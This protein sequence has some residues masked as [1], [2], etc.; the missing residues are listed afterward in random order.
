MTDN[1]SSEWPRTALMLLFARARMI[2]AVGIVCA[3]GAFVAATVMPAI[4]KGGFSI[5]IKAPEVDLSLVGQNADIVFK[6]GQVAGNLVSDEFQILTSYGLAEAVAQAYL[7]GGKALPGSDGRRSGL[8]ARLLPDDSEAV[9][10]GG[11]GTDEVQ[12][13]AARLNAKLIITPVM[14]SDVIKVEMRDHD[15]RFLERILTLF[16][17]EYLSYRRKIWFNADA[18]EFYVKQADASREEWVRMLDHM[19]ELKSETN[20]IAPAVEKVELEKRMAANVGRLEELSVR[21]AKTAAQ[22]GQLRGLRPGQAL[23]FLSEETGDNRLFWQL[24]TDIAEAVSKREELSKNHLKKSPAMRKM[25]QHLSGLYREY[26]ALT[27]SLLENNIQTLKAERD[28]IMTSNTNVHE[29]LLDL[30]HFAGEAGVLEQQSDLLR[31]RYELYKNKAMEIDVQN[32]LL[33]ASDGAIRIISPPMVGLNPVWPNTPVLVIAATVLGLFLTLL[34]TIVQWMLKDTFSLPEEISSDLA[35]PILASFPFVEK[36]ERPNADEGSDGEVDADPTVANMLH[37]RRPATLVW[38][39]FIVAVT[40][41]VIASAQM[42]LD[43]PAG[44]SQ[45]ERTARSTPDAA[46]WHSTPVKTLDDHGD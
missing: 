15:R 36:C 20:E 18:R 37:V 3:I 45:R 22:L 46:G 4:Y 1:H 41:V 33:S 30:D 26:K 7:A 23:T 19:R 6:P 21:I 35:L 10:R 24:K 12:R 34:V 9:K 17:S 44:A 11:P 27:E 32:R 5:L 29:R 8:L 43:T 42:F 28:A 14:K 38:L 16:A 2:V 40:G 31:R 39:V 25:A 13:L